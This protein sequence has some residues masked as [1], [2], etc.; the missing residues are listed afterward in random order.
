MSLVSI[1]VSRMI[2]SIVELDRDDVVFMLDILSIQKYEFTEHQT[3]TL[4]LADFNVDTTLYPHIN[5]VLEIKGL[6][7]LSD[8]VGINTEHKLGHMSPTIIE[9]FLKT[10]AR[11]IGNALDI[12]AFIK[13][14][15]DNDAI[16][17]ND[18]VTILVNMK[19][20]GIFY[21]DGALDVRLRMHIALILQSCKCGDI[22]S[23]VIN[24]LLC[25]NVPPAPS[26]QQLQCYG[27]GIPLHVSLG[28]RRPTSTFH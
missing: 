17:I 16:K 21:T 3:I 22:R 18:I 13:A 7:S 23:T 10:K 19:K 27:I 4:H 1:I 14:S 24:S 2:E 15:L 9:F 6:I 28:C 5:M 26:S 12:S 20:S 25:R 8:I 11:P